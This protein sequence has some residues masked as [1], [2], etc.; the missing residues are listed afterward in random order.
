MGIQDAVRKSCEIWI[1]KLIFDTLKWIFIP[2]KGRACFDT[3]S[4][5]HF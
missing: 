2:L 4:F 3:F 1:L 5:W